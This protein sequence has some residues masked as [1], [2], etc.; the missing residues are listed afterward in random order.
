MASTGEVACF[1]P[2]P[3]EAFLKAVNATHIKF[4][5]KGIL[6]SAVQADHVEGMVGV[7]RDF[8]EMN[9]NL[10]ATEP[11]A[12]ALGKEGIDCATVSF[13]E[14]RSLLKKRQVDFLISIPSNKTENQAFE[15]EEQHPLRRHAVDFSVPLMT[16]LENA[17]MLGRA[18]KK[19]Q[20]FTVLSYSELPYTK[21]L[22][23]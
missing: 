5:H 16:E 7:C 21:K 13:D 15:K 22:E 20:H 4:P 17:K 10:T 11:L 9:Y 18:L 19:T 6:F 3:E 2:S 8:A 12:S 23:V 1:G 14:G